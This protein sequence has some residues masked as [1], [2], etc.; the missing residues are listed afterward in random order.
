M[1][2][3]LPKQIINRSKAGFGLP[4]RSWFRDNNDIL[5]KNILMKEKL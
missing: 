1:E 5:L 2:G 3:L 4:L